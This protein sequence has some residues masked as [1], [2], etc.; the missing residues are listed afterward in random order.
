MGGHLSLDEWDDHDYLQGSSHDFGAYDTNRD[1]KLTRVEMEAYVRNEYEDG[2][3]IRDLMSELD[4][5]GD[6]NVRLEELHAKDRDE[7][8]HVRHE[9]LNEQT[10]RRLSRWHG[11]QVDQASRDPGQ[12][13]VIKMWVDQIQRKNM[14]IQMRQQEGDIPEQFRDDPRAAFSFA[15]QKSRAGDS[16][17]NEL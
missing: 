10:L 16:G 3:A 9:E 1:G 8:G 4:A 12:H 13:P 14:I 2:H 11:F 5:D 15:N 6:D 17:R 7:D